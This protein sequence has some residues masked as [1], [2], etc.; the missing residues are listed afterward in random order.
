VKLVVQIFVL[1]VVIAGERGA[2]GS[3]IVPKDPTKST[4]LCTTEDKNLN[5][6]KKNPKRRYPGPR[7]DG[8]FD[9]ESFVTNFNV[10]QKFWILSRGKVQLVFKTQNTS[11]VYPC[12][13]P[14]ALVN[15]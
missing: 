6:W 13:R 1:F 3:Y 9:A 4:E 15:F 7:A 8:V 5:I 14:S 2:E 12:D 11:M 10:P